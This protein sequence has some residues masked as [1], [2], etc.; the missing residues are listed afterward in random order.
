MGDKAK[1]WFTSAQDKLKG[2]ESGKIGGT[3]EEKQTAQ[4]LV[5]GLNA[6]GGPNGA[7]VSELIQKGKRFDQTTS[8]NEWIKE[9]VEPVATHALQT[10]ESNGRAR[11]GPNGYVLMDKYTKKTYDALRK[12]QVDSFIE[13]N[14]G[15]RQEAE[16]KLKAYF[17]DS[18]EVST[19]KFAPPSGG[20]GSGSGGSKVT[21][22]VGVEPAQSDQGGKPGGYTPIDLLGDAV[23]ITPSNIIGGR[24]EDFS[25]HTFNKNGQPVKLYGIQFQHIDGDWK[26]VGRRLDTQEQEKFT[27]DTEGLSD[28]EKT[29]YLL[30]SKM[31]TIEHLSA[32]DNASHLK[33]YVGT[34]DLTSVAKQQG[35]DVTKP[36]AGKVA[37][38][39]GSSIPEVNDQAS[40]DKLEAGQAYMSG[41][42]KYIKK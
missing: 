20:D 35:F 42:K 37:D 29:Q 30:N 16:Q 39:S 40:Y 31:G 28:E 17:P 26:V 18:Q 41:G 19:E 9:M 5:N 3:S 23:T 33:S 1:Y 15:T 25:A 11:L 34:D 21:M 8:E 10:L 36:T 4:D 2:M 7:D 27:K 13:H 32:K 6:F 38:S 14:G 22:A 24:A 12:E